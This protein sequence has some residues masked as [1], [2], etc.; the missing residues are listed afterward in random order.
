VYPEIALAWGL[1]LTLYLDCETTRLDL[2][3]VMLGVCL[4]IIGAL[5]TRLFVVKYGIRS[6]MLGRPGTVAS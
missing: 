6:W 1:L 3:E 5:T 4:T 2:A